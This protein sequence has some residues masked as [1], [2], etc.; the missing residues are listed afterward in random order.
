MRAGM[1]VGVPPNGLPPNRLPGWY[2]MPMG[3]RFS[4][5]IDKVI[6]AALPPT[7]CDAAIEIVRELQAPPMSTRCSLAARSPWRRARAMH[8]GVTAMARSAERTGTQESLV[9]P[10]IDLGEM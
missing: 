1:S 9:G 4:R 7:F 8:R 10:G 6:A 2:A 5:V 3:D